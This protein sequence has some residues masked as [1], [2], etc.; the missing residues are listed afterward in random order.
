MGNSQGTYGKEQHLPS[1]QSNP[2][3]YF[4][5]FETNYIPSI[6]HLYVPLSSLFH[7]A[8]SILINHI[9]VQTI[10][11]PLLC[12]H[13]HT[14]RPSIFSICSICI[15]NFITRHES[16]HTTSQKIV[17]PITKYLSMVAHSAKLVYKGSC[18]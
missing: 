15:S 17:V 14:A 10:T 6:T 2:M 4:A 18:I 5:H 11:A 3:P 12:N 16:D 7:I 9:I 1:L 13:Y 8:L